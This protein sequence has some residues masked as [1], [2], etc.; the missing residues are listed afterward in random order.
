[1][2]GW[3]LDQRAAMFTDVMPATNNLDNTSTV[4]IRY[5]TDFPGL[6]NGRLFIRIR[7]TE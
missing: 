4:T 5:N 3:T 6:A 7:A 2:T 1:M